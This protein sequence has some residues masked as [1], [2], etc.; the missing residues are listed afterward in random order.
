MKFLMVAIL[1]QSCQTGNIVNISNR[2]YV[3]KSVGDLKS[4]DSSKSYPENKYLREV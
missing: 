2:D 4:I 3:R 1:L